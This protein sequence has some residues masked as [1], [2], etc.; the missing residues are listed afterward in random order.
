MSAGFV[1]P[2]HWT[3]TAGQLKQTGNAVL[4][5]AGMGTVSFS[6]VS[7]SQRWVA[8]KVVVSTNQPATA[9]VIPYATLALNTTDFT[10]LSQGFQRGTSWAGNNDNFSGSL[11]IGPCD[12][13]SVLFYPPPGSTPAQVAQLAGVIATAVLTGTS[14]T[15]RA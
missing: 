5:A 9:V 3:E 6:P 1:P 8:G 12:F 10:T 15:R 13:L 2:A 4:N 7:A 11:D 14:Y